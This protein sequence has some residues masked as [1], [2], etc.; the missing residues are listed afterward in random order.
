MKRED[1]LGWEKGSTEE[2]GLDRSPEKWPRGT[3]EHTTRALR[4]GAETE[5]NETQL[6]APR[7]EVQDEGGLK[8][9]DCRLR[10]STETTKIC[11]QDPKLK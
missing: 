1:T 6:G 5:R 4:K 8:G 11:D 10:P 2:G 7:D 3:Q 9:E